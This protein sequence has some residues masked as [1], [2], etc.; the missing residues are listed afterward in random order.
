M[1]K[2]YSYYSNQI[3]LLLSILLISA[4]SDN[5]VPIDENTNQKNEENLSDIPDDNNPDVSSPANFYRFTT[6][7]TS[8][9]DP[10]DV[11]ILFHVSDSLYSGV[12]NL[13]TQDLLITENDEESS[14][15]ESKATL[16][17]KN[18]FDL[19]LKTA[20]LI[21]VS[22]SIQTDFD[23]LKIQVKKLIDASLPYQEIA[24]YSFSSTTALEL[25]Y[26]TN[27]SQ[28]KSIIDNLQL[29]TSSTDFYGS[30]VTAANSFAN[31]FVELEVTI[32]NL[33]I[34]TDGDDTQASS[35][36]TDAMESI[37]NKSV[38]V[39]GLSSQNLDETN[40][41]N[42]VGNSFYY[43]SENLTNVEA[44]FLLIQN[45]IEQFTRS[46][47]LLNYETP[48]REDNNHFLKIFHKQ[49]INNA[50]DQFAI[51]E[52]T[53]TGFY[54]PTAPSPVT[55]ISPELGENIELV[56]ECSVK[57]K[58]GS[59]IDADRS[60]NELIIYQLFFGTTPE[61]LELVSQIE[62]AASMNEFEI[63]APSRLQPFTDYYWQ[64]KTLDNDFSEL[65]TISEIWN[66][67]FSSA[68]FIGDELDI[69]DQSEIDNFCYNIIRGRLNI[70]FNDQSPS[71]ISNLNGLNIV[72]SITDYLVISGTQ[73][74]SL[75]GLE[76]ISNMGSLLLT[77][78]QLLED[79]SLFPNISQLRDFQLILSPLVKELTPLA[80]ITSLGRITI[81]S[82]DGL[83]N[84]DGLG[85]IQTINVNG[86]NIFAGSLITGNINL[87][88][89]CALDSQVMEGTFL[90]QNNITDNLFN[91]MWTEIQ[92]GNCK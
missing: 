83:T 90:G 34:F 27:K 5:E 33:I 67:K 60:G 79:L 57:L 62:T 9:A 77:N 84:L 50:V 74:N 47:Y 45:E 39:V 82:N 87:D 10:F 36:F 13:V 7:Q 49:N 35:S 29:G 19:T 14:I 46:I 89:F 31:G 43:P 72:S 42:L 86:S 40:I 17:D 21:D 92:N 61:N 88:D 25:D 28:L 58:I 44:N 12:E 59:S 3:V 41:K 54:E 16:F 26:T 2:K 18:S 69:Y 81:S 11:N 37:E 15:D 64:I 71:N 4:C 51:G 22:N 1:K 91:P 48:K 73:I 76:N 30:V 53:S 65:D 63:E 80:T 70:I 24:I 85:N 52:F 6:Y 32:G 68:I 66:F 8:T 23:D 20:L 75:S 56:N 78:N 55:L 38:Y